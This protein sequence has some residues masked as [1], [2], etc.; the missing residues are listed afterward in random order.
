MIRIGSRKR[1]RLWFCL[2]FHHRIL[3]DYGGFFLGFAWFD[4]RWVKIKSAHRRLLFSERAGAAR[5][6]FGKLYVTVERRRVA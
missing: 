1:N 5:L 4:D 6:L 3:H 2:A